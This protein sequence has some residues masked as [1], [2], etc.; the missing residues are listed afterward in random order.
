M[1]AVIRPATGTDN[2]IQPEIEFV[3]VDGLNLR[4]A[5][6]H[7]TGTPL[8]LFNGIGANLELTMPFVDA[9]S[10]KEII[11]FDMPGVGRSELGWRP[12]RFSGL[13]KL[14]ARL[15]DRLGY[16]EV[17][18]AGI[19]WGGAVAQQFAK[20]YPQRC[21]RLVLA[22][23]SAG[24]FMLPGGPRVLAKMATPK[25]Y[26]SGRYMQEVAATIYGGR[27]RDNPDAIDGFA[28]RIIPPNPLGYLYQLIGG[29][30]WT[31]LLWLRSLKQPTLVLGGDDD[32]LVPLINARFLASMIPNAQL[33]IVRGGGHLFLLYRTDEV[34]PVI[35]EFLGAPE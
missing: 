16:P 10:G 6:R 13:A 32:P 7:G 11:V 9:F 35:R 33:H 31:S 25:R 8:L 19:S 23:T 17:D 3:E 15:L 22:A 34:V 21:R 2:P 20:R 30:G 24:T 5:I 27:V 12:R 4:V 1:A 28:S 26:L 14:S 29:L 18:V